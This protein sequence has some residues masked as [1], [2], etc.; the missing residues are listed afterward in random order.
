MDDVL[1]TSKKQDYQTPEYELEFVR[2]V[3]GGRIRL[4]PFTAASNPTKALYF[5]TPDQSRAVDLRRWRGEDG[6]AV[7]WAELA[8]DGLVFCNPEYG[9]N[10]DRFA[11]KVAQEAIRGAEIITLT[12][13]RTDTGWWH[14]LAGAA[15]SGLF[16]KGRITFI[17]TETGEPCKAKVYRGKGKDRVWTGKWA[18]SPAA[19][20]CFYGYFGPR[21]EVFRTVFAGRGRL[22]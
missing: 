17:D 22:L 18:P 20:P 4:D 19:F 9:D 13:S 7:N 21:P 5:C 1:L 6:Y 2:R 3:A 11:A 16:L 12:P 10:L 14:T 8:H 15:D